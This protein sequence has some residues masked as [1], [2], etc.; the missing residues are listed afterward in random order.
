MRKLTEDEIG[1]AVDALESLGSQSMLSTNRRIELFVRELKTKDVYIVDAA[2]D[3]RQLDSIE[4]MEPPALFALVHSQAERI[5]MLQDEL[6]VTA[7]KYKELSDTLEA[8]R[9]LNA[10]GDR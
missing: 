9:K 8:Y 4:G 6:D 2:V 10:K 5:A 1:M 7:A 3:G